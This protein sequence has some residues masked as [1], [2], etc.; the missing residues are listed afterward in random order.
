MFAE[1]DTVQVIVRPPSYERTLLNIVKYDSRLGDLAWKEDTFRSFPVHGVNN[2]KT[3]RQRPE[4]CFFDKTAFIMALESFSEPVLVFLRPRRSGK[5]LGLSTLAHFH[6]RE[7]LP[8]YKPLFEGLAIDEHMKKGDEATHNLSQMLNE[9]IKRF[10][11][12][13]EPYLRMSVDYLIANSIKD[14][15]AESITACVDI[16]HD[17]HYG[18]RIRQL[19]NEYPVPIDSVQW[20]LPRRSNVDNVLEGFWASVKSGL[21]Y[22]EIAKCYITGVSPQSL[23]DNT[24]GLNVVQYVSWGPELASFCGLTGAD[25]CCAGAPWEAARSYQ[26]DLIWMSGKVSLSFIST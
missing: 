12:T 5:S 16:V 2:F 25:V 20:K 3:L 24:S 1:T 10:Y 23:V 7:H 9:S 17:L 8:D 4:L 14:N 11:M 13:Y 26:F 19:S 6:G 18:G 15:A 22:R 21:G